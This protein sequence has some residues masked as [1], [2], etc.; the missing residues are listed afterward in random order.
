[1]IKKIVLTCDSCAEKITILS[2]I[3]TDLRDRGYK[4][5]V[6][7]ESVTEVINSGIIPFEDS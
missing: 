3:K 1:M 7:K 6:E 2:E 5:F 4:V